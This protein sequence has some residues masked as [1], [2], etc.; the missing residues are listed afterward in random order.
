MNKVSTCIKLYSLTEVQSRKQA[1][2]KQWNKY[3][4]LSKNMRMLSPDIGGQEEF[5]KEEMSKLTP[6]EWVSVKEANRVGGLRKKVDPP[7]TDP[8]VTKSKGHN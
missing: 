3:K 7:E 1:I 4:A 5:S 2:S 6:E 8:H